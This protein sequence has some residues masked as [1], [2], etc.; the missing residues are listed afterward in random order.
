VLTQHRVEPLMEERHLHF[1]GVGVVGPILREVVELLDVFVHT[2]QTLM[3]VQ[4]LLKLGSH[5]E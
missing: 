4:K 1:I 3:Q 2:G 5:P